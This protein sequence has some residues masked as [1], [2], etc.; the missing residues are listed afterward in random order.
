MRRINATILIFKTL[1]AEPGWYNNSGARAGGAGAGA[2]EH[3][4]MY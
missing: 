2:G 1:W 4:A 3:N